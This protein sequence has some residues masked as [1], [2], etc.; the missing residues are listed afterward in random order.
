M[1]LER[2]VRTDP[3]LGETSTLQNKQSMTLRRYS[4]EFRLRLHL[5]GG[6]G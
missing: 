3:F 5:G 2:M 6:A 4:F 1:S